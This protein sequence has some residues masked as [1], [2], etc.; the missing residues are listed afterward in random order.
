MVDF[1]TELA[2]RTELPIR[3][4]VRWL[5]VSAGKFYA[6]KARYGKANEHN[7]K[8]PRD[9]WL[10]GW[11]RAAIVDYHGKHPLEG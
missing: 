4:L 11:E 8:F 10:E 5:E 9:F 2:E 6:W 7:G 1:V 3:R